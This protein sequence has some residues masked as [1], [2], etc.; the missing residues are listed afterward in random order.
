MHT[1]IVIFILLSLSPAWLLAQPTQEQYLLDSGDVIKIT[2]FGEKDL[3]FQIRIPQKGIINYPFLGEINV[4]SLT[5]SQLEALIYQGLKGDYLV[6]PSVAVTIEEYRPFFIDGEIK[7]PGGYA[8]QPGLSVNKAAALAGGFTERAAKGK[9]FI[10]REVAGQ[11]VTLTVSTA[12]PILPG[13]II[14][15]QQ[16]FF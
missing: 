14:T 8:Y 10:V 1:S 9:I 5:A 4:T 2:V 12:D 11:Q 7:K 16:R 13:D 15:V 6:S 3:S